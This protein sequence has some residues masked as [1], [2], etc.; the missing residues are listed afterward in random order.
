MRVKKRV[1][2]GVKKGIKSVKSAPPEGYL[3]GAGVLV[4]GAAVLLLT[5]TKSGR[6]LLIRTV[7]LARPEADEPESEESDVQDEAHSEPA[8]DAD[9]EE[10]SDEDTNGDDEPEITDLKPSIQRPRSPRKASAS[11]K[12]ANA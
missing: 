3:A 2:K 10:K 12:A 4:G 7:Q 8:E 11:R 1:K 5:T 6:E 9:G